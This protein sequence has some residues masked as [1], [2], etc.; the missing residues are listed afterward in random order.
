[1]GKVVRKKQSLDNRTM[2]EKMKSMAE[3]KAKKASK[4]KKETKGKK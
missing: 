4:G 2:E 3:L 1:M